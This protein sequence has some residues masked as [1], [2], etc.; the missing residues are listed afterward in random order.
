[1]TENGRS[2]TEAGYTFDDAWK[3]PATATAHRNAALSL[4]RTLIQH[5]VPFGVVTRHDLQ[6]LADW[7]VIALPNVV[8][9][10]ADEVAALRA[11]VAGGGS[12]LASKHT[13]LVTR[14]GQLLPDFALADVFGTS[15]AGETREI[16]T[17]VAPSGVKDKLFDGFS[18]GLPATLYDTQL[19]VTAHPGAE[20]LA[21]LTLPWTDPPETRYAAI[22]TDPPGIATDSPSV[23]LN[24]FGQ[25][26]VAYCAGVIESWRHE[27]QQAVLVRLLRTLAPRRWWVE[28]DAPRSVEATLYRQEDRGRFVLCLINY[29]QE[30]P[31][32]PIFDL[33]VRVRTDGREVGSVS[34]VPEQTGLDFSADGDTVEIRIPVLRDFAMIAVTLAPVA[35]PPQPS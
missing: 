6:R 7:Q 19:L 5:H 28:M 13:S 18:S 34:L 9:L 23:I 31:N 1:M 2:V 26:Q 14:E 8:M 29:Q 25:G 12:L 30:L 21:T 16:V 22:L 20:V 10:S 4:A 24:R 15:Y 33:A 32:I 27:T 11:Y 35:G 3:Q 17:Y